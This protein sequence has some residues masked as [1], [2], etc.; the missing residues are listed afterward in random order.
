MGQ[1]DDVAK[2]VTMDLKQPGNLLFLVGETHDELGGSHYSLVN[3][4]WPMTLV[5]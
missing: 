2:C 4:V 1:V 3:G 5:H